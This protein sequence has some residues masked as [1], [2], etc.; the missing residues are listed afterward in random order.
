MS[1]TASLSLRRIELLPA[2][3]MIA[4]LKDFTRSGLAARA[5]RHTIRGAHPP[6]LR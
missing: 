3:R 2:D 5:S 4:A 6:V 1:A